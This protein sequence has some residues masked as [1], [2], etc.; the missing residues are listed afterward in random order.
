MEK[1]YTVQSSNFFGGSPHRMIVWYT[2]A[3]YSISI[4]LDALVGTSFHSVYENLLAEMNKRDELG[5][6]KHSPYEIIEALQN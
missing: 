3:Q 4:C 1:D 5:L 2:G 6:F